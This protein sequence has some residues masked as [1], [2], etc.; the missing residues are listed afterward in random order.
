MIIYA[1]GQTSIFDRSDVVSSA[2]SSTGP[3][4]PKP[5]PTY[6]STTPLCILTASAVAAVY[7]SS[8]SNAFFSAGLSYAVFFAVALLLVE[9]A[10]VEAQRSGQHGGSGVYATNGFLAQPDKLAASGASVTWCLT[11]DVST[12]AAAGSFIAALFMENLDFGGLAYWGLLGQA[13][14]DHWV[15]GQAIATAVYGIGIVLVLT[16][17][18]ATLLV[19]VRL[20]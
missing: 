16:V 18:Y 1:I 5:L 2:A 19:M 15:V 14:G 17:M 13:M 11:R 7:T 3:N 10:T 8:G 4:K 9:R 20:S 6:T 12:A